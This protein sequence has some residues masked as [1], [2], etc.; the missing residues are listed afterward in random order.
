MSHDAQ[1]DRAGDGTG[2]RTIP[3]I[4]KLLAERAEAEGLTDASLGR[5]D[6]RRV[7]HDEAYQA[8][9]NR[10]LRALRCGG[11][12]ALRGEVVKLGRGARVTGRE[13]VR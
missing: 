13:A 8:G 6:G 1:H 5:I 10:A 11:A 2:P 12:S 9:V 4:P 7:W 3:S